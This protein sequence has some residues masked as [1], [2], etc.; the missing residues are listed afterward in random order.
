MAARLPVVAE[1]DGDGPL[2]DFVPL[3]PQAV[4]TSANAATR[5]TQPCLA[6]SRRLGTTT[7]LRSLVSFDLWLSYSDAQTNRRFA[8]ASRAS[9][10]GVTTPPGADAVP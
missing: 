3:D 5:L 1:L 2:S 7:L 4:A 6:N 10:V 9:R 8:P